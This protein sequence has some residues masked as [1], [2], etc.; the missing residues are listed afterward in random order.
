METETGTETETSQVSAAYKKGPRRGQ[1]TKSLLVARVAFCVTS[2]K[3]TLAHR[4][5]WSVK[6]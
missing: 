5:N 4:G 2:C 3:H 6:L 1:R